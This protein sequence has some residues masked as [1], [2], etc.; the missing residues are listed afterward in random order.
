MKREA[1]EPAAVPPAW[2]LLPR[3]VREVAEII[4]L[5]AAMRL[6]G[7]LCPPADGKK[8]RHASGRVG[9]TYVPR[10]P[11]GI[12]FDRLAS[13]VGDGAARALC[14]EFGAEYL[15][16]PACTTFVNRVRDASVRDY[17]RNSTL[18]AAWIGWLH[19]ITERQVRNICR[20]E[21]RLAVVVNGGRTTGARTPPQD[22]EI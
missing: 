3:Q 13:I 6:V 22:L 10:S 16:L 20:A 7:A 4:G 5:Q 9:I 15:R 21:H 2:L 18:S 11:S 8:P 19:A 17:W 12:V 1:I 14:R